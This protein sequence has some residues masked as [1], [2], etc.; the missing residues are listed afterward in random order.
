MSNAEKPPAFDAAKASETISPYDL[1]PDQAEVVFHYSR[2][3]RLSRASPAVQAL[4]DGKIMK[5]SL[6]KTL[7]MTGSHRMFI[8]VVIFA[9]VASVL[10]GRFMGG[11]GDRGHAYHGV[12][13]GGNAIALTIE[14]VEYALF[15]VILKSAPESGEFHTGAVDVAV[16]PVA[17]AGETPDVFTHRIFFN[18]TTHESFQLLLPFEGDDFFVVLDSGEERRTVRVR[19]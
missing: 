4:N 13:L 19:V 14:P 5:G 16:S 11:W 7:A 15:L 1:K 10:G 12:L 6:F 2:E 8:F 9:L 17:E 18:L 3:R